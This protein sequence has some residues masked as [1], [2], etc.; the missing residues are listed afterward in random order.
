MVLNFKR[1]I[2]GFLLL[3][4]LTFILGGF[5]PFTIY[6]VN[7]Y[8]F[9]KQ[10]NNSLLLSQS[11]I[12]GSNLLGQSF[13]DSKYFWG[14]PLPGEQHLRIE[15]FNQLQNKHGLPS[16]FSPADFPPDFISSSASGVDPHISYESAMIQLDR[17]SRETGRYRGIL[18]NYIVSSIE[19]RQY[20]FMGQPR[21]NVAKLNLFIYES[22]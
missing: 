5:Y 7:Q 10:A 15:K 1:S 3:A 9:P 16:I 18:E 22:Q 14:R 19:P 20:F 2:Q 17:V 6:V 21:V 12:V 13:S 8:F 11:K 4:I